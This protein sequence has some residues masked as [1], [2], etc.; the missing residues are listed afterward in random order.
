VRR[1]LALAALLALAAAPNAEV[2]PELRG[3]VSA[4]VT[5]C[6]PFQAGTSTR[7]VL[8]RVR[9]GARGVEKPE[10]R[11]G[12]ST[13]GSDDVL[14]WA[15]VAG[16]D[17]L[18]ADE[19]REAMVLVP[20]DAT[21]SECRCA[22]A[23]FDSGEHCA[24]WESLQ[25]G[26]CVEPGDVA[27]A[28]PPAAPDAVS[29]ALR[30]S[31]ALTPLRALVEPGRT[32]EGRTGTI[33][34]AVPPAELGDLVFALVPEDDTVYVRPLWRQLDVVDQRAFAIWASECFGV[35]RIVDAERGAPVAPGK[36]NR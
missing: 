34:A 4:E 30:V 14:G 3:R 7:V 13:P 32:A 31:R 16:I 20:S 36:E 8:V 19:V 11:C 1:R 27:A 23:R 26:R 10:I 22:V 18:A 5:S 17:E 24:P 2:P 28:P 35:S 21:H 29:G 25:G 12:A 33:C 6:E 15:R 9:A